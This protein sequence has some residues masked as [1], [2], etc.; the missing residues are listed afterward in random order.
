MELT[1]PSFADV[2][3]AKQF[4][5]RYLPRTPLIH[6]PA[7]DK[8]VGA[9]IFVKHENHQPIGAF[10][11]R[12]GINLIS[13]LSNDERAS[14]VIAASTGNHGQ[15]V[16]YAA[17]EFGVPATIVAPER[18]NPLKVESMQN[19]GAQVIFHGVDFDAARE[20]CEQLA[21][22]RE[23]RYIHSGNEPLLVAGVATEALNPRR[24]S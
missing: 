9:E 4:I 12:G 1:R 10:K 17:R 24:R 2:L 14:G 18:A 8:L 21:E 7:L 22:E 3:K 15:S 13:Q 11:V 16:A 20:Y 23:L 5:A 6:Y 19:L